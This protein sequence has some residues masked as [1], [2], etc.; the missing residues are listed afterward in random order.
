MLA[1]DW[2]TSSLRIYRLDSD[3]TVFDTRQSARGILGVTDAAF[4]TVLEETAGDWIDADHAQI[5]MS[6]MIGSRQGWKEASYVSCPAGLPEIASAMCPVQW[7]S[8][9]GHTRSAQIAPG[10]RCVDESGVN[11]VMR[12]E[13]VQILGILDHLGRGEQFVCLP[14]THSKW[15]RV[16]DNRVISFR[17][18]MSGEVF[19][20]LKQYSILGRTLISA[21]AMEGDRFDEMAFQAGVARAGNPGGML[22]HLFGVRAQVLSGNLAEASSASYLSGIIIGHELGSVANEV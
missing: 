5:I 12:G 15:A 11:D 21:S 19:A 6:G 16:R 8:D 14:G 18:Y 2:G 20:V 7:T 1:I 13:E 10:L 17:T 22:H 3:G 9:S 4:A